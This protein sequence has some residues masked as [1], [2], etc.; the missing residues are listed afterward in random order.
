MFLRVSLNTDCC[1]M[2]D[3]KVFVC[4]LLEPELKIQNKKCTGIAQH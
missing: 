2:A 1:Q 4:A 3:I